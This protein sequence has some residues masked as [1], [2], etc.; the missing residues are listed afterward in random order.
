MIG[1]NMTKFL[2]TINAVL[3]TIS[4]LNYSAEN[5]VN[6]SR[7][8]I[9]DDFVMVQDD[10][11]ASSPAA[12]ATTDLAV[13]QALQ[14]E[15]PDDGWDIVSDDE[16]ETAAVVDDFERVA[17]PQSPVVHIINQSSWPVKIDFVRNVLMQS[18]II[19]PHDT[20]EIDN[21][22]E[23]TEI[24]SIDP[25]DHHSTCTNLIQTSSNFISNCGF[26][27]SWGLTIAGCSRASTACSIAVPIFDCGLNYSKR[28]C[29]MPLPVS[30]MQIYSDYTNLHERMVMA[31]GY[32]VAQITISQEQTD[33]SAAPFLHAT[34]AMPSADRTAIVVS[35]AQKRQN[36]LKEA[37]LT[38]I[39]EELKA[40]L[41]S[42]RNEIDKM[43][44]YGQLLQELILTM[45][46][47]EKRS[48]ESAFQAFFKTLGIPLPD[49][50]S[51]S[52]V[53]DE[54]PTLAIANLLHVLE[55]TV[56]AKI[57]TFDRLGCYAGTH[58]IRV[59]ECE[60]LFTKVVRAYKTL[61]QEFAGV[62]ARLHSIIASVHDEVCHDK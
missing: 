33:P 14:L 6:E 28:C 7:T 58:N 25:F 47:I 12:A 22:H 8:A 36:I 29:A 56:S 18:V 1:K 21:A 48:V 61:Q 37:A 17:Y 34:C 20:I 24:L 50:S 55:S 32:C 2:Y 16:K 49:S 4:C 13:P 44:M 38:C 51:S 10:V 19:A 40:Y 59:D 11:A 62:A 30:G 45:P 35:A 23:V 39:K 43:R 15:Q 41:E 54:V 53:K 60:P 9:D 52:C 3:L 46:P 26:L 57:E 42:V 27:A 31:G 5:S